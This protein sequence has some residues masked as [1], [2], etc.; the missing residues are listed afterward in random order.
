MKLKKGLLKFLRNLNKF[1]FTTQKERIYTYK[2]FNK[3]FNK[4]VI[5]EFRKL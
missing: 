1:I 3:I 2:L 4:E 5:Y